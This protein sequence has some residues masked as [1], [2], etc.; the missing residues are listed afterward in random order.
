MRKQ[1]YIHQQSVN[2]KKEVNACIHTYV[3][4]YIHIHAYILTEIR[5]YIYTYMNACIAV[6][7]PPILNFNVLFCL[8]CHRCPDAP[9]PPRN[10]N[11][12]TPLSSLDFA[13]NLSA[14]LLV[15]I[16]HFYAQRKVSRNII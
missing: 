4:M 15:L 5:A 8:A 3:N 14:S 12:P 7:V 1:T 13:R 16:A 9:H 6:N 11:Q 10:L 2:R